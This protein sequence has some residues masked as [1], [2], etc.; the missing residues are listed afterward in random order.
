[1]SW[2][3]V[4]REFPP[5]SGGG[6]GTYARAITQS[7][8]MAGQKPVVVT[9]GDG[10]RSESVEDGVVVIRLPLVE[11]DDWAAPHPNARTPETKAAW[12]ALG[13][14]AVFSMLVADVLDD[15]IARHGVDLVEFAD[16]GASGWFSLNRRR[17]LGAFGAVRMMT[18]VHSPS[19]WIEE[20]NRRCEPGRQMH[21]LQRMEREQAR[22]SDAVITPSQYMADWVRQNWGIDSTVIRNPL[23]DLLPREQDSEEDGVLFVGRLEYRKGIDTLCR[24]WSKLRESDHRLHLVGQDVPDQRTGVP[25]GERLLSEMPREAS[26]G[27]VEHGSMS[28]AGVHS[29][30]SGA[31]VVVVP[32][33]VDNLPYTCVEAMAAGRV[34]VASDTGGASELIEDGIS[35][36]L[37]ESGSCESLAITLRR[38][39]DMSETSRIEMGE[40][41][42]ERIASMC[43]AAAVVT[44]RREHARGV[45]HWRDI[46]NDPE[47][48]A[49]NASTADNPK[50]KQLCNAVTNS[51]AAFA[52][53]WPTSHKRIVAH[54]SSSFA[55]MLTGPRKVGPIV[56]RRE[57][58]EKPNIASII[59]ST[60]ADMFD[61]GE[62]WKLVAAITAAGGEG[63]VV[64]EVV[65]DAGEPDS[66]AISED[67][68]A[69]I[70]PSIV[71]GEPGMPVGRAVRLVPAFEGQTDTIKSRVMGTA[72][73]LLSG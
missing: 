14:H 36:L 47:C 59:T 8:V 49:I 12:S 65:I 64:P 7:L 71:R 3:F 60:D 31:S 63:V 53:G 21:E 62:A 35:G 25:I 10:I 24:A 41:A 54:G 19:A 27:V 2:C 38:A 42:C 16:T 29:L 6:I 39:L 1:M 51:G 9:V 45:E 22:W 68:H 57:W 33:P 67:T 46:L 55:G 43:S 69:L 13:P 17:N 32:S 28:P 52:H 40:C 18:N 23:P 34:V 72:K 37:F 44:A 73:K 4:S 70:E 58:L 15:V 61:V 26:L 48:V 30:Q 20:H 5:F 11:G 56:V 50:L 66:P